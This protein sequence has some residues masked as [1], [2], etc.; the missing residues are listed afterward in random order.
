ML[1]SIRNER[2][3]PRLPRHMR[4]NMAMA[5]PEKRQSPR[6][7]LKE[8]IS[9]SIRG[10]GKYTAAI[11]ENISSGG[12]R[13][14]NQSFIAPKTRLMLQIKLLSRV[15]TPIGEV[16]WTNHLAHTDNY[17]SGVE[18]LEIDRDTKMYLNDFM[19]IRLETL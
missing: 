11:G 13:L 12:L 18:F 14:T 9:Y 2:E 4:K 1:Y 10:T 16:A 5:L 19:Q 17:S 3:E 8:P 6:I 15:V 7:A